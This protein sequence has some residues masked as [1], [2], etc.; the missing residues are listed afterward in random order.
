M[1]P[2]QIK[3]KNILNMIKIKTIFL[4]V[5]LNYIQCN[6]SILKLEYEISF[7][8]IINKINFEKSYKFYI[9]SNTEIFELERNNNNFR[10]D[11]IYKYNMTKIQKKYIDSILN[12]IILI[13]NIYTD[14]NIR[15]RDIPYIGMS[16]KFYEN[17]RILKEFNYD[18]FDGEVEKLMDKII[19]YSIENISKN[20]NK[21][22]IF[23]RDFIY[24]PSNQIPLN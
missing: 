10:N 15:Y 2:I 14:S 5:F 13:K 9:N 1:F 4:L 24:P 7:S 11:Y 23:N 18:Y 20:N 6:K 3:L 17:S 8:I 21:K 12:K 22:N 16:I 19:I